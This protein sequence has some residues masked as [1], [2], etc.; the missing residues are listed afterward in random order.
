[1]PQEFIMSMC[2]IKYGKI[3]YTK[4]HYEVR[5]TVRISSLFVFG[6]IRENYYLS[7]LDES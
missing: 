6:K 7:F 2:L 3:I 4:I 5:M 1:M